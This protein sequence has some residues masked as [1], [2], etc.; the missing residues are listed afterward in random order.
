MPKIIDAFCFFNELD[1]LEIRLNVMNPYVD[2]FIL[3]E[4]S[5]TQS[6]ISKPFYFEQNKDRYKEFLPKIIHVKVE[7]AVEG[8]FQEYS[9]NWS[10]E[11]FQRNCLLR[12]LNQI[13]EIR[14]D[15]IVLI[16]DC[17]EI[18]FI[19]KDPLYDL[20]VNEGAIAF[21][22]TFF[23]YFLNYRAYHNNNGVLGDKISHGSIATFADHLRKYQPQELWM[24]KDVFKNPPGFG[25]HLSWLGGFDKV[26]EKS[27]SCI[28]PFDKSNLK[29]KEQMVKL[30]EDRVL[31]QGYFNIN[32]PNDNSV[33]LTKVEIDD[34]FPEYIRNNQD[35]YQHLILK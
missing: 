32:N 10:M 5:K 33:I 29:N 30:F 22:N 28:E 16:S 1:L 17:D 31:K 9:S 24:G 19:D 18:P 11:N 3:V 34:S 12:G 4:A 15:D 21:T 7:D 20:L 23:A 13:P 14:Q 8:N 26:I 35:K 27:L 6:L 25:H 2:Y